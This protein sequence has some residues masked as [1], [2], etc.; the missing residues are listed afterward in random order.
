MTESMRCSDLSSHL[1]AS[2]SVLCSYQAART[3]LLRKGRSLQQVPQP[4]RRSER[5]SRD[6]ELLP[7]SPIV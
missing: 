2:V 1:R 7:L 4:L 6:N 5:F 3:E